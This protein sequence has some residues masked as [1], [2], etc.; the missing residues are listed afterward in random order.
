MCPGET[1]I[2]E[3]MLSGMEDGRYVLEHNEREHH[4]ARTCGDP[5]PEPSHLEAQ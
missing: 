3:V 1:S 5:G 4:D 2:P